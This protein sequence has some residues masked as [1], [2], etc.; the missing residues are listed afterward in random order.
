MKLPAYLPS[1]STDSAFSIIKYN[2]EFGNYEVWTESTFGLSS[3]LYP[4]N[5]PLGLIQLL[6]S[7]QEFK[8]RFPNTPRYKFPSDP[9]PRPPT[10]TNSAEKHA[11]DIW[12]SDKA[13]YDNF[14]SALSF[15]KL[16]MEESLD[17]TSK[18]NMSVSGMGLISRSVAFIYD[19]MKKTHGTLQSVQAN[20]ELNKL[21]ETYRTDQSL[22]E[23]IAVFKSVI[24][25][26]A[27]HDNVLSEKMQL[28]FLIAAIAP[29][30]KFADVLTTF[31]RD[32]PIARD[33]KFDE[34]VAR[35]LADNK[36]QR[37]NVANGTTGFGN[38]AVQPFSAA[39]LA[40]LSRE[41]IDR[42]RDLLLGDARMGN[43]AS[44]K[45]PP[46]GQPSKKCEMCHSSFVPRFTPHTRCDP[47]H[48]KWAPDKSDG[49]QGGKEKKK[50]K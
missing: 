13:I 3:H 38:A 8:E 6:L 49:G 44:A 25:S 40:S 39:S 36:R 23:F 18:S 17:S 19:Y 28:M 35:L 48:L 21:S 11:H 32:F 34:L 31:D 20:L 5:A 14:C 7:K 43:G 37:Y 16:K 4:S 50:G 42:L 33:R 47:C 27:Q 2:P 46:S 24:R 9:G 45:P 10:A 41:D 26:E 29:C 1:P 15:L 22:D 30:G 12:N